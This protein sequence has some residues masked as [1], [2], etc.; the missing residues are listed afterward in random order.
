[1]FRVRAFFALGTLV[2]L[3][4]VLAWGSIPQFFLV[5]NSGWMQPYFTDTKANLPEIVQRLVGMSCAS[6]DMESALAVFNQ[7]ATPELS[8]K[9]LFQGACR[10]MPVRQIVSNIQAARLEDDSQVFANSD[11]Q[12]ALYRAIVRYAKGRTAI[13]WMITN[14]KNSPHNSDQLNIHD[15][16]FYKM[17]HDSPQITRVIAIPLADAATSQYFTSHGLIVFG[18]AYG[19]S[20]GNYLQKLVADGKVTR[21]LGVRAALLKPLTE[22][23]VSFAPAKL[24]GPVSGVREEGGGLRISLPAK[25][26]SQ[27][28]TITGRFTNH[29]YPYSIV[30]ADASADIVLGGRKYPVP[31]APSVLHDLQPNASSSPVTL[32][33]TLPA[34][35]TW[36]LA[37]IFGAGKNIPAVLQFQLQNQSLAI[38][39]EFVSVINGILPDAPM[40]T[41]FRPDANVRSSQTDI[42]ILVRVQY[43]V[44]PLLVLLAALLMLVLAILFMLL[45]FARS[46]SKAAHVRVNGKIMTIRLARGKA[47]NVRD[48]NGDVVALIKRGLFGYSLGQVKKGCKVE[49]IKK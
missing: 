48:E 43:P 1:M 7:S 14:N 20:A 36:S 40:P 23:A 30:S 6:S 44:W 33:F 12:Q 16:A 21:D 34:M 27:S 17:L 46:G 49:L 41:I 2:F 45:R 28:F 19:S 18:I 5:Q 8:P 39:P 47:Q 15:A 4:P 10:K 3:L 32:S 42:P 29:F 31:L 35:P 24:V 22:S 13:F 11:Y 9:T 25:S 38:S 37:T 26:H